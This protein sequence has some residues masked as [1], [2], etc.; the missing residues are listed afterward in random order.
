MKKKMTKAQRSALRQFQTFY[1]DKWPDVM[2]DFHYGQPSKH[3]RHPNDEMISYVRQIR[4]NIEPNPEKLPDLR[5]Y[6]CK[7]RGCPNTMQYRADEM[8]GPCS[9]RQG[10]VNR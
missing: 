1:G 4:N 8:C 7:E 10:G 9:E 6:P 2:L 3:R 5:V